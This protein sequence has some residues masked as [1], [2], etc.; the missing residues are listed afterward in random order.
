MEVKHQKNM[1]MLIK[2]ARHNAY[3]RRSKKGAI[4]KGRTGN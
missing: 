4:K 3:V 2:C 1:R